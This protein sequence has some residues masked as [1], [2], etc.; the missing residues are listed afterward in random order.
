MQRKLTLSKG[1]F[2]WDAGDAARTFAVLEA[3]RLGVKTER[4]V[5][6]ALAQAA[7]LAVAPALDS[8]ESPCASP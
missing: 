5:V 3:G 8:K 4:G 2:L 1:A 6:G 7:P